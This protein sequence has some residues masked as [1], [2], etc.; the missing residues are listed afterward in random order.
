MSNPTAT[1][2]TNLQETIT[3]SAWYA[4]N[5]ES[6]YGNSIESISFSAKDEEITLHIVLKTPGFSNRNYDESTRHVPKDV[7]QKAN[8]AAIRK[9]SGGRV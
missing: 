3:Q 1:I 9:L 7:I 4:E 2:L 6:V 5:I 8:Q